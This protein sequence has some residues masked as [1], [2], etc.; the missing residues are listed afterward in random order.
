MMVMLPIPMEVNA[1]NERKFK[2]SR[3]KHGGWM[4]DYNEHEFQCVC[5]G[6]K[7]KD[8]HKMRSVDGSMMMC[9]KCMKFHFEGGHDEMIE[10]YYTRVFYE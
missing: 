10:T 9:K 3:Q 1:E 5:C 8:L 2:E 7:S 4:M 6:K